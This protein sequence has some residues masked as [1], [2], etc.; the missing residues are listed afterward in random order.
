MHQCK[1]QD[2]R[3]ETLLIF[4]FF[5]YTWISQLGGIFGLCVGGSIISVIELTW[6]LVAI[7]TDKIQNLAMVSK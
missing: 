4:I 1:K 7:L 6:C 5:S 3:V 2:I